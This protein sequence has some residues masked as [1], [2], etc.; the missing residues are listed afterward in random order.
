MGRYGQ[1][2]AVLDNIDGLIGTKVDNNMLAQLSNS[3]SIDQLSFTGGSEPLDLNLLTHLPLELLEIENAQIL[4]LEPLKALKNL[5]ILKLDK[6]G[7]SDFSVLQE[8]KTL[9]ILSLEKNKLHSIPDDFSL[10]HLHI[11]YLTDNPITDTGFTKNFPELEELKFGNSTKINGHRTIKLITREETPEVILEEQR[12]FYKK[13]DDLKEKLANSD[14][15]ALTAELDSELLGNAIYRALDGKSNIEWIAQNVINIPDRRRAVDVMEDLL[16]FSK[17]ESAQM[18]LDGLSKVAEAA[19]DLITEALKQNYLADRPTAAPFRASSAH[20]HGMIF[21]EKNAGP[22]LTGLFRWYFEQHDTF[23]DAHLVYYKR[24]AKVAH[25]T[26]ARELVQPLIDLLDL[27]KKIV[28][29]E[30]TLKKYCLAAISRLGNAHDIPALAE[31]IDLT[32]EPTDVVQAYE[33]TV[34]KLAGRIT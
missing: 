24:L 7:I 3:R 11:F 15:E 23:S 27:D 33:T 2:V 18:V 34:K 20:Y 6:C 19:A 8:L 21:A 10:P 26:G 16:S 29:H 1:K 31:R 22:H 12:Q 4:S 5:T 32:N 13:A 25:K 17:S 30:K 9:S 28:D 14:I